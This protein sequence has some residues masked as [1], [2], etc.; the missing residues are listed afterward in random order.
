MYADFKKII[1]E[2]VRREDRNV[3]DNIEVSTEYWRALW[4]GKGNWESCDTL[5]P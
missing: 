5:A 3:F 1:A 2:R 4:E